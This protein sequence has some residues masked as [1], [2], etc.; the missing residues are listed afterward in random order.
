MINLHDDNIDQIIEEFSSNELINL[1]DDLLK[2]AI[3]LTLQEDLDISEIDSIARGNDLL[4]IIPKIIASRLNKAELYSQ[5]FASFNQEDLVFAGYSITE[6]R[7]IRKLL[8]DVISLVERQSRDDLYREVFDE[9]K[10]NFE[11]DAAIYRNA[12]NN[13]N[14]AYRIQ[15]RHLMSHAI[16]T[17]K[18]VTSYNFE[19]FLHEEIGVLEGYR[20]HLN[21]A[22]ELLESSE[23][24]G[25]YAEQLHELRETLILVLEAMNT[26]IIGHGFSHKRISYIH[27]ILYHIRHDPDEYIFK[28][29]RRFA[30][31][32]HEKTLQGYMTPEE[33]AVRYRT[34]YIKHNRVLLSFISNPIDVNND[35]ILEVTNTL[36]Q[37]LSI[38]LNVKL[39]FIR[40]GQL[41]D[42][43]FQASSGTD[44]DTKPPYSQ[45]SLESFYQQVNNIL[46]IL[47]RYT[48]NSDY[49]ESLQ[50]KCYRASV[51]LLEW[52]QGDNSLEI[53]DI[54][55]RY[56][57]YAA[58]RLFVLR[59]STLCMFI[60]SHSAGQLSSIASEKILT[61]CRD[62]IQFKYDFL[63]PSSIYLESMFDLD[64]YRKPVLSK[65]EEAIT[66][67]HS[68][69]ISQAET[70]PKSYQNIVPAPLHNI[71][72]TL[73]SNEQ[74]SLKS[75]FSQLVIDCLALKVQ[76]LDEPPKDGAEE[77]SLSRVEIQVQLAS[78][79]E[80]T[81]YFL[82]KHQ[83]ENQL[84]LELYQ[85]QE[86]E[87]FDDLSLPS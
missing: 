6:L 46:T 53:I 66:I 79:K 43:I 75:F 77:R 25:K 8:E 80:R 29:I 61:V 21:N 18:K 39:Q 12:L 54:L 45:T 24:R 52:F 42:Q 9:L 32:S 60:S 7:N 11:L 38:A 1:S 28:V 55:R 69:Q 70:T 63:K 34:R 62:L 87:T 50:E 68:T 30:T 23:I 86:L 56:Q 67:V 5:K 14:E 76:E 26:H 33:I 17:Y 16:E 22:I 81:I 59:I 35:F 10:D 82:K 58:R 15:S 20:E 41:C 13:V 48:I 3:E 84:F 72:I 37:N 36:L 2:V 71:P 31:I 4:A 65:I 64:S 27:D 44:V 19:H 40:T 85:S 74:I 78:S 83:E 73:D 49:L 47:E 57:I 51:I